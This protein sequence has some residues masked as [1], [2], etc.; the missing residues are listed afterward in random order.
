MQPISFLPQDRID[1]GIQNLGETL[2]KIN[3]SKRARKKEQID[4]F[5]SLI[6]VSLQGIKNGHYEEAM[7]D[8]DKLNERATQI[9]VKAENE[10]R[11]VNF[12]ESLELSNAKKDLMY[13]VNT[14]KMLMD[15]YQKTTQRAALLQQQG[16][17]DPATGVA[18]GDW[19]NSK[20]P[21]NETT[22]PST[23]IQEQ[24]T[25]QEVY[26]L[27]DEAIGRIQGTGIATTMPDGKIKSE[28]YKDPETIKKEVDLLWTE[29]KYKQAMTRMGVTQAQDRENAVNKYQGYKETLKQKPAPYGGFAPQTEKP[30]WYKHDDGSMTSVPLNDT[31][32]NING[33][34]V[35]PA[36][37]RIYDPK[38]GVT[39]YPLL[40]LKPGKGDFAATYEGKSEKEL[41]Q[42]LPKNEQ[43][44]HFKTYR[45]LKK[46]DE[47]NK[48]NV[49]KT[50]QPETHTSAESDEYG[51]FWGDT[52]EKTRA[53][54]VVKPTGTKGTTKPKIDY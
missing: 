52:K 42:P 9:Y 15:D 31:P 4:Q 38:T 48:D 36:G 35:K 27:Q 16:K 47:S 13:K 11:P 2:S 49:K 30:V 25:P 12:K 18:L 1:Q 34:S 44:A 51:Q 22:F 8:L 19:L 50:W 41:D 6:D 3:E 21:V 26:K 40:V 14:S 5:K 24:Y 39:T 28:T 37:A 43:T 10:N 45:D 32:R 7:G 17:L 33:Q 46:Y 20:K 54:K 29:P 23:L 53:A